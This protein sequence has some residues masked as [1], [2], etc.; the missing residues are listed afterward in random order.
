MAET[1]HEFGTIIGADAKFKGDLSFDS[2]A[3][4]MGHFEGSI[5]AKGLVHIAGGSKCKASVNA[6][7][8]AVEGHIEGN[9]QATDRVEL[10]PKG[11]ITGDIVATRMTMADGASIVGHCQIGVN[12]DTGKLA[13]A[14]EVKTPVVETVKSK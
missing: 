12:G 7:E 3:K 8:V 14:A 10:K 1:S 13:S 9:V 6:K 4:V 11:Q 5:K 2:A